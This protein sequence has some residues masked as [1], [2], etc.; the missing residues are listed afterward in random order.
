[1]SWLLDPLSRVLC[2]FRGHDILMHFQHDRLSLRCISCGYETTGWSL[3]P[4]TSNSP[5]VDHKPLTDRTRPAARSLA[6]ADDG[7][8]A[9]FADRSLHAE[10]IEAGSAARGPQALGDRPRSRA[11]R[12]AG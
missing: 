8:G 1:M 12:L 10:R 3:G 6:M 4:D 7:S 5:S 2:S 11:V 9:A